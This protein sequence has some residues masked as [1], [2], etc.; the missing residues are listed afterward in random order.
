MENKKLKVGL[1]GF[2][3]FALKAHLPALLKF[4]N[5][6][7]IE[8]TALC[9][10]NQKNMI[11]NFDEKY[12]RHILKYT[13]SNKFLIESNID[14]VIIV[15]PIPQ[16]A[17]AIKL[18]LECGKFVISEKPCAA[19]IDEAR[20]LLD[21]YSTLNKEKFWAVAE[22]YRCKPLVDKVKS[23]LKDGVI[24]RCYS[25]NFDFNFPIEHDPLS[26]RQKS[27]DTGGYI[28]DFCVHY[29]AAMRE[30]FGDFSEVYS[31]F[32]KNR[33]ISNDFD[34]VD[35][36]VKF[37]NGITGTFSVNF[38][39]TINASNFPELKITGSHGFLYVN[40]KRSYIE[41]ITL[42]GR[43]VFKFPNDPW[44]VGG[45]Y[46][47]LGHCF[48]VLK[49]NDY[50]SLIC[51]PQQALMD[52]E[53]IESMLKSSK[54]GSP[55]IIRGSPSNKLHINNSCVN[56]F[57]GSVTYRP[58][59]IF[60]CKKI[61]DFQNIISSI[62]NESRKI[63]VKAAGQ[64]WGSPI[65]TN[66]IMLGVE[67]IEPFVELDENTKKVRVSSNI[68]LGE[69]NRFLTSRNLCL[70]THTCSPKSTIGGAVSTG[71]HGSNPGF[72]IISDLV[73]DIT[74]LLASG[75]LLKI[76]NE[77]D[78]ELLRAA[79]VSVGLLGVITELTLEV[80]QLKNYSFFKK[81]FHLEDFISVQ[82]A[83][84]EYYDYA[85][86]KWKL[87]SEEIDL[88]YG[89]NEDNE[90]SSKPLLSGNMEQPEWH[91]FLPDPV[92][93][94][95]CP[96]VNQRNSNIRSMS[97]QYSFAAELLPDLIKSITNSEFS[98]RNSGRIIEFK[99]IKGKQKSMLGSNVNLRNVTVNIA[100]SNVHVNEKIN[101]FNSFESVAHSFL[102]RPHWG[103]H[104][105]I[106]SLSY[107]EKIFPEWSNFMNIRNKLDPDGV[108]KFQ[109][110]WM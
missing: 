67:S 18:A 46:E 12:K 19:S 4:E 70:P 41:I 38:N 76:N 82:S 34:M 11:E 14:L 13:D 26:W 24:G 64:S 63:R 65:L 59:E 110:S 10:R 108:F 86:A 74:L 32:S 55:S 107:I 81:S 72:G 50:N 52:M 1:W 75:E 44:D 45:V 95:S 85:W 88:V 17:G 97:S 96:E 49:G 27:M 61:S 60:Y 98:R 37:S 6:G 71:S 83:I 28:L 62:K 31:N 105:R 2:G 87:G 39:S 92:S 29:I 20:D 8:I 78:N 21:Y 100:W 91:S 57:E 42:A 104:H 101:I 53:V 3:S 73:T 36:F 89:K 90:I 22:N 99:Y 48:D 51:T 69:L 102:G 79:R 106:Q 40:F 7:L 25:V 94:F 16:L 56:T 9:S 103:K 47:V 23:F 84:W 5:D 35:A 15:L 68:Q 93:N 77:I 30:W 43:E 33:A 109:N 80:K 54:M 66:D 58:K